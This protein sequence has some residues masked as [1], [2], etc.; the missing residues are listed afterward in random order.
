MQDPAFRAALNEQR[1]AS[2][3]NVMFAL[4]KYA[5]KAVKALVECLADD[6]PDSTRIKA[7]DSILSHTIEYRK[8]YGIEERLDELEEIAGSAKRVKNGK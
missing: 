2:A 7:A 3:Q 1:K 5:N 4:E 6:K 8:L